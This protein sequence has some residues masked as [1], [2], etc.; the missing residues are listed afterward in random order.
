MNFCA[1][2]TVIHILDV[3]GYCDANY[4]GCPSCVFVMVERAILWKSVIQTLIASL[5]IEI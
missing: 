1:K 3:V 2:V 5:T 4:F